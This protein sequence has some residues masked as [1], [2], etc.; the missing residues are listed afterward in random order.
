MNTINKLL[1]ST[2]V[3]IGCNTATTIAG[4]YFVKNTL[5]DAFLK[6]LL[7]V[8]LYN[9]LSAIGVTLFDKYVNQN[10]T[11]NKAIQYGLTAVE[12][13]LVSPIVASIIN[14]RNEFPGFFKNFY[15]YQAKNDDRVFTANIIILP[16]AFK[17]IWDNPSDNTTNDEILDDLTSVE[18]IENYA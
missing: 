16:L 5:L 13:L 4:H 8:S 17:Y 15:S 9:T 3:A 12:S 18:L 2:A 6:T 14:Q 10:I 7:F 1:T 11:D